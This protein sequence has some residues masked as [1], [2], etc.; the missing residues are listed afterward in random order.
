MEVA[1]RPIAIR[2]AT[3]PHQTPTTPPPALTPFAL[4]FLAL[5]PELA[6]RILL[7]LAPDDLGVLSRTVEQLAGVERDA[8]LWSVWISSVSGRWRGCAVLRR[9]Q[10]RDALGRRKQPL[11]R[12][13][14]LQT[15]PSRIHHALSSPL[16]PRPDAAELVRRG[17]LRGLAVISGVKADIYWG[18]DVVSA[19]FLRPSPHSPSPPAPS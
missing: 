10:H 11:T 15:A 3:P 16:H 4:G 8:Y 5:P 2:T 18:S 6:T 1:L 17:T 12:T 19:A 14:P 7:F 13:P 9:R